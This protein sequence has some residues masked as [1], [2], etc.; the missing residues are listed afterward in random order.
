MDDTFRLPANMN[1]APGL[2]VQKTPEQ[3][4]IATALPRKAAGKAQKFALRASPRGL[5][6]S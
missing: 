6:T 1:A 4:V 2:A 3:L 5:L